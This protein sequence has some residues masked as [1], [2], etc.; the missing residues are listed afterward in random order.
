MTSDKRKGRGNEE[1]RGSPSA[2]CRRPPASPPWISSASGNDEKGITKRVFTEGCFAFTSHWYKSAL[3]KR[4]DLHNKQG[5]SPF[6]LPPSPSHYPQPS[7]CRLARAQSVI[8]QADCEIALNWKSLPVSLERS[9][10]KMLPSFLLSL[11]PHC[12]YVGD[13]K[14]CM[15]FACEEERMYERMNARQVWHFCGGGL[16]AGDG[17]HTYLRRRTSRCNRFPGHYSRRFEVSAVP[18][19]SFAP[20]SSFSI[21]RGVR[22]RDR[23]CLRRKHRISQDRRGR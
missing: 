19:P 16:G 11:L 20:S 23:C 12:V 13:V 9:T 1:K 5:T 3:S 6:Q 17:R 14:W 8:T 2:S 7:A 21:R 4:L 18:S 10:N 22:S 15:R